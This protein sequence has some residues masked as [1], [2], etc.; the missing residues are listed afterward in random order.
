MTVSRAAVTA[1]PGRLEVRQFPVEDPSLEDAPEALA[2]A[3]SGESM[4]VVFDPT[5]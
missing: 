2:V 1:A 3:Q 4:Q 5:L